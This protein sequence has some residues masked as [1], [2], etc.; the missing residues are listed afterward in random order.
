MRTGMLS[1][2]LGAVIALPGLPSRAADAAPPFPAKPAESEPG[3]ARLA[4]PPDLGELAAR[5]GGAPPSTPEQR[6]EQRRIEREQVSLALR[7]LRGVSAEERL[8]A[9][10][11]LS[12]YP[13]QAAERAL[14][15]ALAGDSAADVRS[16]AA[17][18]LGQVQA[19]APETFRALLRAVRDPHPEVRHAALETLEIQ[20]SREDRSAV[21]L[22]R[23]RKQLR[24][25]AG[26]PTTDRHTREAILDF[27]AED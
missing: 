9:V 17:R 27:L 12:A 1:A 14:A 3:E 25:L 2:A 20:L 22:S 16:A 7:Q 23:V 26:A 5:L 6:A 11:Q 13:T 21:R 10:E 24:A 19:P 18:G 15:R 8:T 4:R